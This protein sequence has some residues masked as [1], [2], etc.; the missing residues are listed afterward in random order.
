[1]AAKQLRDAAVGSTV[2]LHEGG[3]AVRFVVGAHNYNSTGYALL[4]RAANLSE[5]MRYHKDDNVTRFTNSDL[6]KY[7]CSTYYSTIVEREYIREV[8][9]WGKVFVP[10][11]SMF[12]LS[13][14]VF[15]PSA[16]Y[17]L[18]DTAIT[19]FMLNRDD[20]YTWAG[21]LTEEEDDDGTRWVKAYIIKKYASGVVGWDY[22]YLSNYHKYYVAP[23]M[24]VSEDL[25]IGEDGGLT[26]NRTPKITGSYFE[27]T[28]PGSKRTNFKL[29]YQVSDADG[30]ALTVEEWVDS[31]KTRTW[32]TDA[33]AEA[34]FQLS[35]EAFEALIGDSYHTLTVKVS[36]GKD[37]AEA[38][39]T[40]YKNTGA[41]YR[42]WVGT[43]AG[44]GNGYTWTTRELFHDAMD[45]TRFV[46]EPDLTLEKNDPG[47]LNFKVPQTNPARKLLQIKK[48]V[49]SVEEDGLEIWC[50]YVTEMTRDYDLDIEVYCT[51]E[52][53]YLGDMGCKVENQ[54]YTVN[55]LMTLVTTCPDSRFVTEGKRFLLGNVTVTKPTDKADDKDETSYTTCWDALNTCLVDKFGGI[56]RV[57]KEI[58]MENGV[59]VWYRYL[60]YLKDIGD[61]TEQT[62]AFGTNL[63]DLSYYM[64]AYS[65]VNSVKAFGYETTGWWVFEKTTPISAV[66]SNADSIALYG[67]SQRY[68]VVDGKKSTTDSLKKAAQTEL[69]K[70]TSGLSGGLEINAADLADAGVDVDRLGFLKKTRI[71]SEPHGIDAWVLCTKEVIPL[72]SLDQKTFTF[73]DT[74]ENISARLAFNAGTAGKAWGAI[75]STIGY[76]KGGG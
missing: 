12:G 64:K 58:K 67:L 75:Q 68:I 66:A 70:Q 17:K 23:C 44:Q 59:Q 57:R 43:I 3:A 76:I 26:T 19:A 37:T 46:L 10:S 69:D 35:D 71:T 49:V 8:D 14:G 36:D 2:V 56:L 63:L 41:G 32:Q 31:V 30:D 29:V 73:G 55:A 54:V 60:D 74:A 50:G 5:K 72:D 16:K 34:T 38:S 65:I 52:L 1:M 15:S 53:G 48:T 39:Y 51:G 21:D 9:G 24:F 28:T 4:M 45:D 18:S 27:A 7:L 20:V 11:L 13:T 6:S 40:F 62:I 25:Y 33:A 47:S 42:I 22:D 61:L